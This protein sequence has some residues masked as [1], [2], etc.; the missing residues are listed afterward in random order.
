MQSDSEGCLLKRKRARVILCLLLCLALMFI[1]ACILLNQANR[2]RMLRS[3]G[4]EGIPGLKQIDYAYWRD[5]LKYGAG[6]EIMAF[7]VDASSWDL[8]AEWTNEGADID[9]NELADRLGVYLNTNAIADLGLG[10]MNCSS[11]Y[12]ADNR[13]DRPFDEQD[14]YFAYYDDTDKDRAILFVYR[15]HHLYGM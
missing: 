8:P 11:W 2:N 13:A 3:V 4:L 1:A 7:S 12:F 15:G 10:G 6:Y 5:P 14:F 9:I